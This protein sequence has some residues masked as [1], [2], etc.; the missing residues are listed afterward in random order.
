[1]TVDETNHPTTA[2]L[3]G[4]LTLRDEIY[5]LDSNPR[6][7][8]RV[9]VTLDMSSVEPPSNE[10]RRDF[11]ISWTREHNGGKVF[12]TKLGHFPA[13]WQN[14]GFVEHL[15]QGMRLVANRIDDF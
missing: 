10:S 4:S 3:N 8:S 6:P 14:P 15:L 11:P 13:V 5:V 9:L 12:M 2:H 1:V 7:N